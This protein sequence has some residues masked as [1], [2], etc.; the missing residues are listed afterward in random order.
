MTGADIPDDVLEVT[1]NAAP[2]YQRLTHFESWRVA[3]FNEKPEDN[4]GGI[5][6]LE[7]HTLT[8]EVFILLKGS[9]R[10]WIAGGAQKP[11]EPQRVS[12]EPLQCYNV[13]KGTWHNL[14]VSDGGAVI[15]VENQN[16]ARENSE[17]FYFPPKG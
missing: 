15:I 11:N 9:C 2:G 8:D 10:L 14:T 5:Q 4:S 7:R 6:Y 3:V 17:Y 1:A 13:K 12:M 16:T